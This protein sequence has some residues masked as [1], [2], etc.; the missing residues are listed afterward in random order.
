MTIKPSE[1]NKS[2]DEHLIEKVAHILYNARVKCLN[3]YEPENGDTPWSNG[4]RSR[5]WCRKAIRDAVE[6]YQFLDIIKDKGQTFIFSINGVPI[7]FYKDNTKKPSSKLFKYQEI[8]QKQYDL[9]PFD[10]VGN[11]KDILWR[12]VIETDITL[13]ISKISFIGLGKKSKKIECLY[14]VETR[15]KDV[16]II[17]PLATSVDSDEKELEE[18]AISYKTFENEKKKVNG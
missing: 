10:G 9:F 15:D 16:R 7:K 4:V 6:E 8:E 2:L 11:P 18:I 12:F 17:T 14:D 3:G 1:F 5:E 13:D